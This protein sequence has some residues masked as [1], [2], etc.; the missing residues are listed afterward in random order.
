M[1]KAPAFQFYADDWIRA[2]R[3]LTPEEKG[4]WIDFLAFAFMEE[5]QGQMS[6][7]W[8]DLGRM[9]GCSADEV[10][11][12]IESITSKSICDICV[13]DNGSVTVTSRRMSREAKAKKNNRMRQ[14]RHRDKRQDNTEVTPPSSTSSS[15]STSRPKDIYVKTA[16]R[17]WKVWLKE[18]KSSKDDS[19]G[20]NAR[21]YIAK[22][23]ETMLEATLMESIMGYARWCKQKDRSPEMRK[24]GANFF[25]PSQG[26]MWKDFVKGGEIDVEGSSTNWGNL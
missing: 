11:R 23:L 2:T 26:N 24:N 14:Q 3:I 10:R 13:T 19:S 1:G 5:E 17:I 12:I 6:G 25:S 7:S 9:L 18:V 16:S 22:H 15:T 4:V 21:K 8:E 20:A